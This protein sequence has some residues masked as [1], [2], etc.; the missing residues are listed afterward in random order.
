MTIPVFLANPDSYGR[1]GHQTL[2]IISSVQLAKLMG[3]H[4]IPVRYTYFSAHWNKYVDFSRNKYSRTYF[5]S[6]INYCEMIGKRSDAYGNTKYNLM[7]PEDFGQLQCEINNI[8]INSECD[9]TIIKLPFDQSPG[10]LLGLIQKCSNKE[11]DPIFH[12]QKSSPF[13]HG[14]IIESPY[15]TIHIRRG[16]VSKEKYPDWFISDSVYREII[17]I[18]ANTLD[19]RIIL[20]GQEIS[21]FAQYPEI[22]RLEKDGRLVIVSSGSGFRTPDE[23]HCFQIMMNACLV[24]GGLSSFSYVATLI[25]NAGFICLSNEKIYPSEWP[26]SSYSISEI[27][28]GLIDSDKFA[29]QLYAAISCR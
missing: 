24:I 11:W 18:I 9:Y 17:G 20:I 10:R 25:G 27:K 1:F 7:D 21:H 3:G 5:S 29:R 14:T 15:I 4:F 12:F 6:N 22:I 28:H 8:L 13:E 16:D 23:V 26:A 2:R 19:L